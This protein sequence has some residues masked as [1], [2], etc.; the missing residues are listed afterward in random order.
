MEVPQKIKNVTIVCLAILLLGIYQKK[1]KTIDQK[2]TGT[3]IF[4]EALLTI[5]ETM[6]TI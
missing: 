4:P 3:S 5:T 6:A 2:Y 1:T